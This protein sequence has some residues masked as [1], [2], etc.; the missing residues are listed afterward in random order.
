MREKKKLEDQIELCMQKL[1]RAEKLLG[2]LGSEKTRWSEAAAA[3]GASLGNV[4][5]DILLASG[6]VAYLGAFTVVYRDSLVQDW[7]TACQAIQIPCSPPPFNLVNVLGEPV[8]GTMSVLMKSK[9]AI[10]VINVF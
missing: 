1:E 7:H 5:G 8:Q 2:G 6:I 10:T 3:L 4:I 9:R